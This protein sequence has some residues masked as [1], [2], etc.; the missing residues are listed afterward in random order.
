MP[1]DELKARYA[2]LAQR[3]AE[4]AASKFEYKPDYRELGLGQLIKGGF[5]RSMSAIGS[6]ITDVV[7]AMIGSALGYE[8]YAKEQMAEA[9]AKRQRA[10]LENPTGFRSYKDIRG[11]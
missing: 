1:E 4:A 6:G 3:A 11:A 2:E 10:E 5:N 7:P 8:D 9:A